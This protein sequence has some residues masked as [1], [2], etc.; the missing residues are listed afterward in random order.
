MP[1]PVLPVPEL[2]GHRGAVFRLG[3]QLDHP[4]VPVPKYQNAVLAG[5][6]VTCQPGARFTFEPTSYPIDPGLNAVQVQD[7]PVKLLLRTQ[8]HSQ[9]GHEDHPAL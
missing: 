1:V 2:N 5:P 8:R 4:S 9:F 6:T 3:V 7:D